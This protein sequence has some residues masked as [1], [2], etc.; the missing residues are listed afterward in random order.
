ML[1][2]GAACSG[3]LSST[4]TVPS[5]GTL[6]SPSVQPDWWRCYQR[7][8]MHSNWWS[9]SAVL[10]EPLAFDGKK[11]SAVEFDRCGRVRVDDAPVYKA[12]ANGT[13]SVAMTT[14]SPVCVP[15]WIRYERRHRWGWWHGG[16]SHGLFIVAY[17]ARS[18]YTGDRTIVAGAADIRANP[19]V[20]APSSRG[21][22]T[23]AGSSY[24]FFV[25]WTV[26]PPSPTPSPTPTPTPTPFPTATPQTFGLV[27]PVQW[28]NEAFSDVPVANCSNVTTSSAPPF[29][30]ISN[31]PFAVSGS[32]T[33]APSCVPASAEN[34]YLIATQLTSGGSCAGPLERRHSGTIAPHDSQTVE[35]WVVGG[36][37]SSDQ[38][39]W[40]FDASAGGFATQACATYAFFIGTLIGK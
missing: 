24:V 33:L 19:W 25:A 36:P 27:A 40:V 7:S 32:I 11:F 15:H 14:L 4:S 8:K 9:C 12:P 34:L 30:A 38:S 20:F 37:V 21:L 16:Q 6:A 28:K 1:L 39:P 22:T 3:A 35:G 31:G 29:L 26:F 23:R 2:L 17:P 13:L 18:R 10:V 5:A